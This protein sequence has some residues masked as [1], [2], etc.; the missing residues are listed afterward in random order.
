MPTS[1]GKTWKIIL[2]TNWNLQKW[3]KLTKPTTPIHPNGT[4]LEHSSGSSLKFSQRTHL[5]LLSTSLKLGWSTNEELPSIYKEKWGALLH[6]PQQN[7]RTY[8]RN[9]SSNLLLQSWMHAWQQPVKYLCHQPPICQEKTVWKISFV[10]WLFNTFLV[11]SLDK[12]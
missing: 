10:G 7:C 3:E 1:T 2:L 6:Q 5:Q 4:S 8:L 11:L 9:L 12:Y